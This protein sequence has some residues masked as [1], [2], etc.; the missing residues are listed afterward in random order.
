MSAPYD[1]PRGHTGSPGG[2]SGSCPVRFSIATPTRNALTPLRRCVGSV[3]G[4]AGASHQHLVQ[5]AASTDGSADWLRRQS[6]LDC[7]SEPDG[8][9]Y[10]GIG[11]A[12]RRARGEVVSWLNSDEQYLPGTLALVDRTLRAMPEVDVVWGNAIVVS[13]QGA[14]IAG[15]REIALR[16]LYIANSFLN[17]SSCTMFFRR[18]LLDA[19]RLEFDR[20]FRYA[21]DM[22]LVLRLLASGA[23]FHHLPAYLSL[24][25]LDGGNLSLRPEIE[26]EVAEISRRYG[27]FRSRLARSAVLIGRRI[28]RLVHGCYRRETLRYRFAIDELPN[29]RDV[30][31]AGVGGR[32][33]REQAAARGA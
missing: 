20:G 19:G 1:E 12:W 2:E 8:G 33:G 25:G 5:D 7:A 6:D 23:R 17:A 16:R 30:V 32:Y 14:A 26:V 28:E 21:A 18:R 31:A 27:G 11:R 24:Y 9:M 13:S 22:D 29:Y 4:Q 3:R 10:D 15:R